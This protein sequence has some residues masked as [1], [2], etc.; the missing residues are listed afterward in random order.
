MESLDITCTRHKMETN[1]EKTR[2]MTKTY[3]IQREIV[4]FKTKEVG[5]GEKFQ[6]PLSSFLR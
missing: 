6:K 2:P 5:D 1:A 4:V 3:D